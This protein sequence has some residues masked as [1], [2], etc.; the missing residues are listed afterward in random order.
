MKTVKTDGGNVFVFDSWRDGEGWRYLAR[1]QIEK[2]DADGTLQRCLLPA[3]AVTRDGSVI[4][5]KCLKCFVAHI[6]RRQHG[7]RAVGPR[8]W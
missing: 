8:H 7:Q 2:M 3:V 6:G 1:C 4:C 5:L